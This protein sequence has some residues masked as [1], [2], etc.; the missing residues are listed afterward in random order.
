ME[1]E[2]SP[3]QRRANTFTHKLQVLVPVRTLTDFNRML[4]V[5]PA[6]DLE[7]SDVTFVVSKGSQGQGQI[8][9]AIRTVHRA[10]LI[11]WK[12]ARKRH[13]DLIVAAHVNRKLFDLHG[14]KLVVPHGAGL[15]RKN[16]A[17]THDENAPVGLAK[18]QLMRDGVVIPDAIGLPHENLVDALLRYCPA[19]VGRAVPVGDPT[20]DRIKANLVRRDEFR[21]QL[22]VGESQKL[23]LVT[24][25]WGRYSCLGE[26]RT[27]PNRL[28][29][30]LPEDEFKV[31][32]ILHPNDWA[33]ESDFNI[34][35][36]Y[37]D[38]RESGLAIVNPDND[39]WQ[40]VLI[41]A[42]MVIGD[43]GSV[44]FYGADLGY[45]F[46][47]TARGLDEL[48]ESSPRV[49]LSQLM[50]VLDVDGDLLAQVRHAM[51][52]HPRELALDITQ[53][54][55]GDPGSSLDLIRADA[56]T[57]LGRPRPEKPPRIGKIAPSRLAKPTAATAHRV[58][59]RPIAPDTIRM[60]RYPALMIKDPGREL[61][62]EHVLMID[63]A[64]IDPQYHVN[65]EVV[66]H[67]DPLRACRVPVKMR[68][69]R[70]YCRFAQMIAVATRSGCTVRSYHHKQDFDLVGRDDDTEDTEDADPLDPSIVAAGLYG[71]LIMTRQPVEVGTTFHIQITATSTATV[72]V[73][74]IR[75][76][77][78]VSN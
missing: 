15:A 47:L 10:K 28:L 1:A 51:R 25:T 35:N 49:Q 61:A 58:T 42:D 65:A 52:N 77:E 45:P 74:A 22:G 50:P 70:E 24:S 67:R 9:H 33:K 44:A 43:H 5:L 68:E 48:D 56:Y 29:A 69:L 46:L 3:E 36:R 26:H 30:Q 76:V 62:D 57:L 23:V 34:E 8:V 40:A 19:A 54:T 16:P 4:D 7:H 60:D 14:P 11:T 73:K 64:E 31:A 71:R 12:Q 78:P 38:A 18:G 66:V 41:A 17:A 20:R 6:L 55:L 63:S 2:S 13:F 75:D 59:L 39:S 32:V 72:T 21:R 37:R 27:L 53:Q